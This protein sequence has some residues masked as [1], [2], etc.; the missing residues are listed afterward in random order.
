MIVVLTGIDGS[1]KS[2]AARALVDTVTSQGR[3][4]LLLANYAGRRTLTEWSSRAGLRL[5]LRLM[6]AVETG[7]R[8]LN[9]LLSSLR[10]ARFD[11]LVVMDRHLYCQLALREARGLPRG[12]FLPWLLRTLPAADAVLHLDVPP[13]TAH[14]RIAARG[15]DEE[16]L[17]DLTALAAA[18]RRLPEYREF[19][20]VDS[21]GPAHDVD[22]RIWAVLPDAPLQPAQSRAD[23]K[24]GS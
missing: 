6:D 7:I 8:V 4:A 22:A 15:I 5:P 23:P 12:R 18:Y 13:A 16:S 11:G 19:T 14:E 21:G 9:V 3:D 20:V 1:G 10:A 2:T 24:A 17:A